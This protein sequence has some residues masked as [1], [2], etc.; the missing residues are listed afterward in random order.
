MSIDIS[1]INNSLTFW[2]VEVIPE[3]ITELKV[4]FMFKAV[5]GNSEHF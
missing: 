5:I 1:Y 2:P 4:V 3:K